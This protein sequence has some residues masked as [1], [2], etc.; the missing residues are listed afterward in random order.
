MSFIYPNYIPMEMTEEIYILSYYTDSLLTGIRLI[1]IDMCV[2]AT[3]I[4][5]A[6]IPGSDSYFA[7]NPADREVIFHKGV[8]SK[9]EL[10]AYID[11][12]E[13]AFREQCENCLMR[14]SNLFSK[15]TCIRCSVQI[16][17]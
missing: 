15:D 2:K 16:E 11:Q 4:V 1:S 7:F 3:D 6:L 12:I 10:S 8:R 14:A 9:A 13:V 17:L 5:D